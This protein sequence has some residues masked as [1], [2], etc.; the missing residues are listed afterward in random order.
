MIQDDGISIAEFARR[1]GI[2]RMTAHRWA[3]D[4]KLG[5]VEM[6]MGARIKGRRLSVSWLTQHG[7]LPQVQQFKPLRNLTAREQILLRHFQLAIADKSSN[8]RVDRVLALF[9]ELERWKPR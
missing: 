2:P 7:F 9:E 1:R 8:E 3:R 5:P 4:G 6:R